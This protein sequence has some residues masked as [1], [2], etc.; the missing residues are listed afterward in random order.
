MS[1]NVVTARGAT[2]LGVVGPAVASAVTETTVVG[3]AA[4]GAA[5]VGAATVGTAT[6]GTT[7]VGT[8][9]VGT[10]TESLGALSA[11]VDDPGATLVPA[12]EVVA[13]D[14]LALPSPGPKIITGCD[15][16]TVV[17]ATG[18]EMGGGTGLLVGVVAVTVA[19]VVVSVVTAT[20][21]ACSLV[22]VVERTE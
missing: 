14:D 10:T 9:A 6:V 12:G 19:V 11:C 17:P 2:G 5:A 15:G 20:A 7:G 13:G 4:V 16:A 8:T 18:T 21:T 1:G 3:T 22:T